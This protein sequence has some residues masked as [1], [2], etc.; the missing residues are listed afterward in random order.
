MINIVIKFLN[1]NEILPAVTLGLNVSCAWF[2]ARG[3]L[4]IGLPILRELRA[5]ALMENPLTLF[6]VRWKIVETAIKQKAEV[7][8]GLSLLVLAALCGFVTLFMSLKPHNWIFSFLIVIVIFVLF[9]GIGE[10]MVPLLNYYFF[11][12]AAKESL[13][14]SPGYWLG[15]GTE[16]RNEEIAKEVKCYHLAKF[17]EKFVTK[18]LQKYLKKLDDMNNGKFEKRYIDKHGQ[19]WNEKGDLKKEKNN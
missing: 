16:K 13:H 11:I 8:Y 4:S 3:F 2:L 1:L 19:P 15:L 17:Y 7:T 9:W 6:G 14:T 5:G 18:M 12:K 10:I